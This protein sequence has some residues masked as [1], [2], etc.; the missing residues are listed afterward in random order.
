MEL[1]PLV[2]RYAERFAAVGGDTH[3]VGSP[4]GAWLVLALAAPAADGVLREQ[5]ADALR[6]DV[7]SA[8]RLLADLLERPHPA[9]AAALAAW[10]EPNLTGLDE[11]CAGLPQPVTTGPVPTARQADAWAREHTLEL[12][13][14]FPL[15]VADAVIVLA[16]ALA[17]RVSW[18]RPFE[19][20]DGHQLG[21]RWGDRLTRAL[22]TPGDYGHV[23]F[24]AATESAGDVAVHS[25]LADEEVEVTSVL[26]A[27]DVPPAAVLA[28]AHDIASTRAA[29]QTPPSRSLFDLPLGDGPL[30]TITEHD[31]PARGEHV[32]AVLPPGM[33]TIGTSCSMFRVLR[34]VLPVRRCP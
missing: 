8:Q 15:G 29:F 21:G 30:W 22:R 18:L 28:V 6:T 19:L 34:S 2:R 25:V 7:G 1:G 14:T 9:V 13:D 16:S 17:T 23:A 10:M 26:A 3:H 5:I 12:I 11:W 4:L 27:A 24:I 33:R 32:E 31:A 20:V